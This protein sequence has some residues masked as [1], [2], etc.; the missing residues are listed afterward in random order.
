MEITGW[1]GFKVGI[2]GRLVRGLLL[3]AGWIAPT[4]GILFVDT[5]GGGTVDRMLPEAGTAGTAVEALLLLVPIGSGTTTAGLLLVGAGMDFAAPPVAA[6]GSE[7]MLPAAWLVF[8][9]AAELLVLDATVAGAL[10]AF[11]G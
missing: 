1:L 5:I 2:A 4:A 7:A 6:L 10:A 8:Q 9:E 11:D 3:L